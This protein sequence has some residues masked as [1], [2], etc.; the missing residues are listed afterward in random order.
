MANDK[1]CRVFLPLFIG[2]ILPMWWK[3]DTQLTLNFINMKIV[4][5]SY[6]NTVE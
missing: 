4:V 2:L 1:L 3:S 5:Q 6:D